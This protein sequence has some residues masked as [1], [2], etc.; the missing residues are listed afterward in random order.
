[1][2]ENRTSPSTVRS[3]TIV[4][5]LFAIAIV[6]RAVGG[7]CQEPALKMTQYG[8][9]AWRAAEGNF[10]GTLSSITQTADGYLWIGTTAGLVRF[11]GIQFTNWQ[12]PNA[13]VIAPVRVLSLLAAKDGSLWIGSGRGL[14]RLRNNEFQYV[15]NTAIGS[16]NTIVQDDAGSIW[17]ARSRFKDKS[18]P[19]C[20]VQ[21]ERLRCFGQADGFLCRYGETVTQGSA[22]SMWMSSTP[23]VCR[24]SLSRIDTY[25]PDGFTQENTTMTASA[26]LEEPDGSALVGFDEPGPTFGLEELQN[27]KWLP[28]NLLGLK[29]SELAVTT[30]FRDREGGL[31]I[32]TEKQGVYHIMHGIADHFGSAEGLS[33]DGINAV[34]QDREGSIWVA[35]T[36]GL[37][38][39]RRLKISAFGTSERLGADRF[40]SV[41]HRLDGSMVFGTENSLMFLDQGAFHTVGVENGLPGKMVTSMFED[42]EGNLWVGIEDQLFTYTKGKFQLYKTE[43]EQ[44]PGKNNPGKVTNIIEDTDHVIWIH[45]VGVSHKNFRVSGDKLVE[46]ATPGFTGTAIRVDPQTGFWMSANRKELV[47]FKAGGY[48]V[49]KRISGDPPMGDFIVNPDRS[50]WM[51]NGLGLHHWK[52]SVWSTLD[53]RDGL[54]CTPIEALVNDG[55]GLWWLYGTCGLMA[56]TDEELARWSEDPNSKIAVRYVFDS[57]DGAQMDSSPFSPET[58]VDRGGHLWFA[59][60][61]RLQEINTNPVNLNPLPPPVH[62]EQ[63]VADHKAYPLGS[64]LRLPP[65][66]RDLSIDYTGL[67]LISPQKVRFRYRLFGA[68]SDW[69]DVGNRRQAFYMN[70][71][72]GRYTFQV[73]AANNDGLWNTRGDSVIFFIKPAFYQTI[74]FLVACA[75]VCILVVWASLRMRVRYVADQVKKRSDERA[76]ERV[77]VA[78]EL[79]DT[80]LQG[81]HALMLRFQVASEDIPI[82][83]PRGKVD[84]ALLIADRVLQEGRERVKHLREQDNVDLG[85][86]L[87]NAAEDLNWQTEVRFVLRTENNPKTLNP[88]VKEEVYGIMR[89]ALANAFKHANASEVGVLIRYAEEFCVECSDNGSGID[90][91]VLER[92]GVEGHWGLKGMQ[93]RA[94]R[95]GAR[96]EI[97]RREGGGTNVSIALS[98]RRAYMSS[99]GDSGDRFYERAWRIIFPQR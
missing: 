26:I 85:Q 52:N 28:F 20:R 57:A 41:I 35:T 75:T 78:R 18:G 95:I 56:I 5:C 9:T 13:G 68:D 45:A 7:Y 49:D 97:K 27:G 55:R 1:M 16:V 90:A 71:R 59:M 21:G 19:L 82:G 47:H 58:S 6:V 25:L 46:V 40:N 8:H 86:A 67:S 63:F 22:G 64:E 91:L 54:P 81:V 94:K 29:G 10:N 70:L 89:E 96:F 87:D 48:E 14:G 50:I 76:D 83:S 30:L 23:G 34:Y 39:F 43:S 37:D 72:P 44:S 31:W 42:H 60:A 66:T 73:I 65:L 61:A 99:E 33:S 12:P 77:R 51:W 84:N 17:I 2:A 38:R 98:A 62:I 93:E 79:H 53:V 92:G 80:L 88:P 11:D 3:R 15:P 4:R 74:W 36:A 32:G 24:W 69:Q